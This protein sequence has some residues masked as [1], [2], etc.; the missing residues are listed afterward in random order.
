MDLY[1]VYSYHIGYEE[2]K[3]RIYFQDFKS[4]GKCFENLQMDQDAWR[5]TRFSVIG[6]KDDKQRSRVPS[7]TLGWIANLP[8][9]I[10]IDIAYMNLLTN[11]SISSILTIYLI[12]YNLVGNRQ[13]YLPIPI[14]FIFKSFLFQRSSAAW[15]RKPTQ[16]CLCADFQCAAWH[17]SLQ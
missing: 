3:S 16:A 10:Y 13:F 9:F 1:R 8:R 17:V 12:S 2:T 11:G 14:L 6:I 4:L 15:A 7:G 5:H